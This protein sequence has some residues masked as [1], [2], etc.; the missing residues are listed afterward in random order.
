MTQSITSQ[1]VYNESIMDSSIITR[2]FKPSVDNSNSYWNVGIFNS[3][4]ILKTADGFESK[5]YDPEH[6]KPDGL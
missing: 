3:I 4:F 6:Y 5:R 1:A 2:V